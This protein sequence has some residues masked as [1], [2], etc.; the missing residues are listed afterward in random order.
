MKII[1][2]RSVLHLHLYR[3][4][5]YLSNLTLIYLTQFPLKK[6]VILVN[7]LFL[8]LILQVLFVVEFFL[9]LST[10]KTL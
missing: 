2:E 7:K 9:S 5:S 6:V 4:E 3:L 1:K 10:I 8:D